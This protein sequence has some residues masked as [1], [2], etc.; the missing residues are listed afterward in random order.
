MHSKLSRLIVLFAL[1]VCL[2]LQGLAAVTMPACLAHGQEMV[3]HAD[4]DQTEV[5]SHCDQHRD[6]D[7]QSKNHPSKNAPCDKCISC[8]LSASMAIMP[9][10]LSVGMDGVARMAA[11]LVTQILDSVPSSLYYPPR[12]IFA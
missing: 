4:V 5:M 2:P 12:S 11:S 6:S 3:I 10:N 1:L 8:Y 7:H 9:S